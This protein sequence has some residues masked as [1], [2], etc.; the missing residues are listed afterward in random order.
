M[1]LW[2]ADEWVLRYLF[3][4]SF[5]AASLHAS[6]CV[7]GPCSIVLLRFIIL[8]RFNQV[9]SKML[10]WRGVQTCVWRKEYTEL[11]QDTAAQYLPIKLHCLHSM[12]I[13]S[14]RLRKSWSMKARKQGY[15]KTQ[16]SAAL[17]MKVDDFMKARGTQLL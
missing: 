2:P 8:I 17:F 1:C 5:D 10:G 14:K 15:C 3:K 7:I 6:P 16:Y 11:L 9:R 4:T 13:S 12:K